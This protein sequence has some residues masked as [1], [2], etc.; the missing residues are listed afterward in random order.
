MQGS[1]VFV[2]ACAMYRMSGDIRKWGG[3]SIRQLTLKLYGVT[4]PGWFQSGTLH[5]KHYDGHFE[6]MRLRTR[7]PLPNLKDVLNKTL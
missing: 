7:P 2:L 4:E 1:E 3:D 6:T 5:G